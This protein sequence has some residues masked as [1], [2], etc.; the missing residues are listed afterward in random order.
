LIQLIQLIQQGIVSSLSPAKR[1][2]QKW[3]FLDSLGFEARSLRSSRRT[4]NDSMQE[5]FF[6]T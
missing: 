5:D 6:T 3:F 1:R 2:E 4:V